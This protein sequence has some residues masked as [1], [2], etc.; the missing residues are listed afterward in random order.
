MV[1]RLSKLFKKRIA[2]L[3]IVKAAAIGAGVE[4]DA[5][6]PRFGRQLH[7]LALAIAIGKKR[8]AHA[9]SLQASHHFLQENTMLAEIPAVVGRRLRRV[10]RHQRHLFRLRFL[11]KDKEILGRITFDVEFRAGETVVDQ[12]TQH[13]Q[14]GKADMALVRPR[15]YSQPACPRL[16]CN[17][18]E[19]R[20]IRPRKIAT[21]A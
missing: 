12:R 21:V 19:M 11:A 1:R 13:R 7:R 17:M 4:F 20:D 14:I 6:R 8:D 16:Q 2:L 3:W 10:I 18:P 9:A 5:R 15:V